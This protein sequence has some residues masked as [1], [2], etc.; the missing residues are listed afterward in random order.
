VVTVLRLERD[1]S[2]AGHRGCLARAV[3]EGLYAKRSAGSLATREARHRDPHGLLSPFSDA[4]CC[5]SRRA[6]S[7]ALLGQPHG[8]E[9]SAS[10]V[11]FA[12]ARHPRTGWEDAGV[13]PEGI[14]R[15]KQ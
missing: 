4:R 13:E 1:A 5:H 12:V 2:A 14:A 6:A 7:D 10:V 15:S 8:T 11:S 9:G 3:G